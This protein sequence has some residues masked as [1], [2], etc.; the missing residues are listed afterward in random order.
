VSIFLFRP[1]TVSAAT[2]DGSHS[3]VV[4]SPS[5][6][7]ADGSATSTVTVTVRDSSGNAISGD[8]VSLS[9]TNSASVDQGSTTLGSTGTAIFTVRSSTSGTSVLTVLDNGAAIANLSGQIIFDTPPTPTVTPTPTPLN[10]CNDATPGSVPQLVSA[11]SSGAHQI[12]LTW[13]ESTSPVSYYLLSYGLKSGSYEYGNPNIGAK[14]TTSTVVGGLATGTTYYFAVK[15]VNGCMP[16]SY[17]NELSAKAGVS[18]TP[19][20]APDSTAS[21]D[22]GTTQQIDTAPSTPEETPTPEPSLSVRPDAQTGLGSRVHTIILG[23]I[24]GGVLLALIGGVLLYLSKKKKSTWT[25]PRETTGDEDNTGK[26]P[27]DQTDGTPH[28]PIDFL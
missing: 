11:S 9:L 7:S 27:E 26:P 1:F 23:S 13:I 18:V 16:G 2:P 25:G 4:T 28:M 22:D 21:V 20:S 10:S 12:T 6:L 19:T 5:E 8:S 15:A 24:V 14:G 17:S 3:T